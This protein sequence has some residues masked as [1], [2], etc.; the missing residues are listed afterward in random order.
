MQAC[1]GAKETYVFSLF[2]VR[3]WLAVAGSGMS[4]IDGSEKLSARTR[5]RRR[6]FPT[7]HIGRQYLIELNLLSK[8]ILL[9]KS[10]TGWQ[11]VP[12]DAKSRD[13]GLTLNEG[14]QMCL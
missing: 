10:V 8:R 2:H 4:T 7:Y 13:K 9:D 3:L 5:Y 1:T 6:P 12:Q 11:G 14:R